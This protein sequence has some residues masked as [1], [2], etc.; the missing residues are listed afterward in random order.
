MSNKVARFQNRLTVR[1]VSGEQMKVPDCYAAF[2]FRSANVNRR[3]K[4]GQGHVHVGRITG[5][6]MFARAE[7]SEATIH[8][9]DCRAARAWFALVT[10]HGRVAEIHAPSSLE[11][12]AGGRRHV[13]KLR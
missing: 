7:N 10:R 6:A 2:A 5:D 8:A 1:R 13:A 9:R 3:F 11:Q 4:R 12:I